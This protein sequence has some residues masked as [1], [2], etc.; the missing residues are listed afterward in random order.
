MFASGSRSLN[1]IQDYASSRIRPMFSK[2]EGV[3]S[4]PP[5]GGN[6]RTIVIRIDPQ[7]LRSYKLT[8][9]EVIRAVR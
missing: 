4:P 3:S 2:I 5:L 1:E 6:Q 9:E 7:R 8:P